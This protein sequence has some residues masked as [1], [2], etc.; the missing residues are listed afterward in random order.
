MFHTD[1]LAGA[2][3]AAWYRAPAGRDAEGRIIRPGREEIEFILD[4]E[5]YFDWE[6]QRVTLHC[7]DVLWHLSG[8]MTIYRNNPTFPYECLVLTFP[9][10][11]VSSRQVAKMTHWEDPGEAR[12]FAM[13]LLRQYHRDE[14]DKVRLSQ[15][16]Y[17]RMAWNAYCCSLRQP[18][19]E[20]PRCVQLALHLLDTQ[21]AHLLHLDG[22]AD[23][24]GVSKAHLHALFKRHLGA[25]PYQYLLQ[26]R[27]QE[28]RHLL[29]S[30]DQLVKEI[31]YSC[32]FHDVVNFCRS[33]KT[34]FQVSPAAYRA[35]N[36]VTR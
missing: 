3:S 29:A 11:G 9:V 34:R 2:L 7:G 15:Y 27:L 17:T 21:F 35:R 23:E 20:L 30:T 24:V 28:A 6:G 13:E 8:E 1:H 4:G 33:F 12:A 16:V 36:T 22:I 26:R 10:H 19:A 25:S 14:V 31:S 32:G 18:T 5:G